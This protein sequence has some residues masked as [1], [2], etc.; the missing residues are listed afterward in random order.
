MAAHVDELI[1]EIAARQHG[2]VAR[3]QLLRAGVG[4]DAVRHRLETKRIHRVHRGVYRVGPIVAPRASEMAA[5]LACG[6]TSVLSHQSAAAR[7]RMTPP[8]D[9]GTP[10]EVWVR[11]AGGCHRPG[12]RARRARRLEAGEVTVVEGIPTTTPAR[13]LLDLA[14]SVGPRTLEQALAYAEKEGLTRRT[15]LR[16]LLARHLRHRGLRAL[17]ALLEEPAGPA[18]TRSAAE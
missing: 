14:G 15:D 9:D 2:I 8:P 3:A 7:W 18:L 13:T 17:R 10:V 1:G 16:S 5:V 6:P 4:P 12:I 11:I